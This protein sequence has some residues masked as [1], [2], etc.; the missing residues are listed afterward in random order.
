MLL[1]DSEGFWLRAKEP[2]IPMSVKSV[3]GGLEVVRSKTSIYVDKDLWQRFKQHTVRSGLQVSKALESLMEEEMVDGVLDRA[4]SQAIGGESYELDFEPIEP[5]EA[6]V[7][8]LVRVMRDD[9]TDSLL[10]Q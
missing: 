4:F 8:E 7:S 10:G 3:H 2:Y 9:R 1:I 6:T 5:R